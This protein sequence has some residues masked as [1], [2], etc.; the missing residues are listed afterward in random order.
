MYTAGTLN[1]GGLIS[2]KVFT[3]LL[4]DI[5]Q[6]S[7]LAPFCGDLIQSEKLSEI[8]PPLVCTKDLL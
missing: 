4:V 1:K 5:A 3:S 8:K 6:E 7:D 2:K